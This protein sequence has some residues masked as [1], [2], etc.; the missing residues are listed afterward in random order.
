[1]RRVESSGIVVQ[2]LQARED[3]GPAAWPTTSAQ[4]L[5]AS[6]LTMSSEVLSWSSSR[7]CFSRARPASSQSLTSTRFRR[8]SNFC[9]A[10]C[11]ATPSGCLRLRRTPMDVR[12]DCERVASVSDHVG[13]L[14]LRESHAVGHAE[15]LRGDRACAFSAL[16]RRPNATADAA[17]YAVARVCESCVGSRTDAVVVQSLGVAEERS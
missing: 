5:A 14:R 7:P 9:R 17:W 4:L 2:T 1:M 8:F 6:R 16:F 13:L 12:T 15:D 10:A 3:R 11:G